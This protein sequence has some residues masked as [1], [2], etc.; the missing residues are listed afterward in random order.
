LAAPLEADD[1]A[2]ISARICAVNASFRRG[3]KAKD[4][5]RPVAEKL[6]SAAFA[7]MPLPASV[8]RNAERSR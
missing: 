6:T 3:H 8:F 5:R 2:T 4:D 1:G 7:V